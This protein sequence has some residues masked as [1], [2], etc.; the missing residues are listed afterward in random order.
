MNRNQKN[1][2]ITLLLDDTARDDAAMDLSE[3]KPQETIET[4]FEV[5]N[6][7]KSPQ[8]ART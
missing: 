5:A 7:E 8:I 6:D 3:H 4:F 2:L 1:T